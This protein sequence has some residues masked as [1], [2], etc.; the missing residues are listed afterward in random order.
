MNALTFWMITLLDCHT[1]TEPR[2]ADVVS[3]EVSGG[4]QAYTFSVGIS[5]PDTGCDQYADWWEVISEE[6]ALIYRRILAH[7]HVDEQPF[8]RS[9][10]KISISDSQTVII[11]AHMNK[12]GYGGQALK[13][14]VKRGFTK[15]VLD[16]SFA[17]QLEKQPP[18]PEGC[19][20]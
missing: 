1:P 8:V 6:G 4:S 11:R 15:V 16:K 20:F 7:S 10:G 3:V 2:F 13:G 18:L 14:S 12:A 5:S 17:R 9:G 19:D